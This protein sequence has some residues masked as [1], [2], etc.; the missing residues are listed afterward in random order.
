MALSMLS[1][2]MGDDVMRELNRRVDV[3]HQPV[4]RVVKDFLAT[5][6]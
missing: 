3:Q 2:H 5:Q 6:P 4:E 1:N